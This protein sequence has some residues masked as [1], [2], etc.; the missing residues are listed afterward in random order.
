MTTVGFLRAIACM[1]WVFLS[2]GALIPVLPTWVADDLGGAGWQV[3]ATVFIYAAASVASRPLAGWYL[4]T[5]SP[6]P[7][8]WMSIIVGVLAVAGT[9]L[10]RDLA[11]MW[12]LRFVEGAALGLFYTAA[13]TGVVRSTPPARRGSRLAYFSVPLFLG[14]AVGPI[15][16]DWALGH[17]GSTGAWLF[18]A[19]ILSVGL[20]PCLPGARLF[21]PMDDRPAGKAP[22]GSLL[23][24]LAHPAARMPAVVLAL[25]IAG[26]A[27]F[28]AFVPLY[29]PQL[30]LQATGTVF[31]AYST[32]V[33]T[34]RVGGARF[35]D[36]LP[37]VPLVIVGCSCNVVGL[38][39][40]ASWRAPGGLYVA[41]I[42]MAVAIGLTYTS[43]MQVA[44]T[45]VS[46]TEEGAVVA[47]YSVAYDIGAGIGA[48]VLG[49]LLT[50]TGSYAAVFLGGAAAAGWALLLMFVHFWPKR[51]RFGGFPIPVTD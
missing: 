47:A 16:G 22:A 46:T 27:A 24:T 34:I 33:L 49:L 32:V 28:Q 23:R 19:G 45:G 36:R 15:V 39:I 30:G 1:W 26:W 4:R 21:A 42:L 13:A 48:V 12:S 43:L 31:L 37:M 2:L 10:I 29:G 7:M 6:E 38:L 40:A 44:L 41:A 11:W 50:L 9:P 20:L 3:G 5:R 35:F 18:A 17:L 8:I 14:V 25:S 51:R